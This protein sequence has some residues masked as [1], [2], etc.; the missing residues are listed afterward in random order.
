MID[1]IEDAIGTTV[2]SHTRWLNGDLHSVGS[3]VRRKIHK[4]SKFARVKQ[5]IAMEFLSALQG[6]KEIRSKRKLD[7]T[8]KSLNV[9]KDQYRFEFIK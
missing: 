5:Q 1:E 2:R 3:F 7:P 4:F 6:K 9:N 8:V